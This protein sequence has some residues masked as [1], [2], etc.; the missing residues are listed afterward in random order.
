M[1]R[2]ECV[3][4]SM[5]PGATIFPAASMVRVAGASMRGAI[6]TIV[7]LRTAMSPRYHGLPVPSTMRP[8]R[9]TR[10]NAG[11]CARGVA[12][13]KDS[14]A[15]AR[16]KEMD[17]RMPRSIPASRHRDRDLHGDFPGVVHERSDLVVHRQEQRPG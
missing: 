7:S 15:A 2:R 3:W 13:T 16:R 6:R 5:N 1:P 9:I 17:T 11:A 8:L 12:T 4:I 14:D 10:S